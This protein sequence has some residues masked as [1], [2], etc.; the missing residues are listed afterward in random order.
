[1]VQ[2]TKTGL[3]PLHRG[4]GRNGHTG[5]NAN[6]TES[7]MVIKLAG[8]RLRSGHRSVNSP[9]VSGRE[10]VAIRSRKRQTAGALAG[11]I[12]DQSSAAKRVIR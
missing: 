2:I 6:G 9:H 7:R 1:M 8:A 3:T 5:E 4:K 11:R 10:P 12:A